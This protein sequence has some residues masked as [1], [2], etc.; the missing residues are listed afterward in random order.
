[1]YYYISNNLTK[2]EIKDSFGVE[3]NAPDLKGS[4]FLN[5]FSFPQTLII[6]DEN[7]DEAIPGDWDLKLFWAKNRDIQ[8]MTLNARIGTL[9]GKPSFKNSVSNR[10]LVFVTP[11]AARILSCGHI[12]GYAIYH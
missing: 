10:C 7:P 2:K 5:G 11:A 6:M 9:T 8:K 4:G 1:M 12:K 3:Y